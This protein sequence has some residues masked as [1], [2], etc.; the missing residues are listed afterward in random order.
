MK[1]APNDIYAL[2]GT[3]LNHLRNGITGLKDTAYASKE[4]PASI[5]QITSI[6]LNIKSILMEIEELTNTLIAF[7][8]GAINS[9]DLNL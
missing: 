7:K 4:S 9:R 1:I 8:T 5:V 6:G 2:L 3:R